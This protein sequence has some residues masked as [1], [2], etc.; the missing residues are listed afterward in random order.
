MHAPYFNGLFFI[1][2][3]AV[4]LTVV[5]DRLL[6]PRGRYQASSKTLPHFQQP[7]YL[8]F[9]LR[10]GYTSVAIALDLINACAAG[11]DQQESYRARDTLVISRAALYLNPV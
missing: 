10:D 3:T 9:R 8:P 1:M 2:A 11:C 5:L 7:V 6:E 4:E